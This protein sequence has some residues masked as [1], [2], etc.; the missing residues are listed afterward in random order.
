MNMEY[1]IEAADIKKKY[2]GFELDIV[3]LAIP[4]G[5]ATALIGKTERERARSSIS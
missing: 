5:F 1:V 3:S 4:K 2:K